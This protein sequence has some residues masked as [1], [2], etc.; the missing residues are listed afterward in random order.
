MNKFIYTCTTL[1]ML[2]SSSNSH[3][4]SGYAEKNYT[5]LNFGWG[6]GKDKYNEAYP[7][8][9]GQVIGTSKKARIAPALE[10]GYGYYITDNFRLDVS[11]GYNI[12]K[13]K[14]KLSLNNPQTNDSVIVLTNG[15]SGPVTPKATMLYHL[16]RITAF[17]NAYYDMSLGG[18]VMPYIGAGGG[19]IHDTIKVKGIVASVPGASKN[20]L[21]YQMGV[22]INSHLG[23]GW[24]A[25]FGLKYT[26][27]YANKK[28]RV[29]EQV[30]TVTMVDIATGAVAGNANANIKHK[31]SG[32]ASLMFGLRKT[33]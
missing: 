1:L 22:G 31:F 15:L 30:G 8:P 26:G 10:L 29:M 20:Q 14:H 25:T 27:I 18:K 7:A 32:N 6:Q 2:I 4:F 24:D 9:V 11:A 19:L 17:A 23:I 5:F 33:F 13:F 21:G 3:S 12:T 16:Q 28:R